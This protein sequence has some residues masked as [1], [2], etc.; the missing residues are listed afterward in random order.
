MH[1]FSLFLLRHQVSQHAERSVSCISIGNCFFP[2]KR[3][4][5]KL[6]NWVA[7]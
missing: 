3:P 5:F 7:S 2:T 6:F 4:F 1:I